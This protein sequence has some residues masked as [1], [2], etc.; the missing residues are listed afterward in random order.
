MAIAPL[1]VRITA[2][3]AAALA[4]TSAALRAA[5]AAAA[6]AARTAGTR[7]AP[8]FTRL[9]AALRAV[10][11]AAARAAAIIG[12]P[13]RRALRA[14]ADAA[15][16]L[17]RALL[18]WV[19][20]YGSIGALLIPLIVAVAKLGPL[21]MLLAPAALAAAGAFGAL[22]LGMSGVGDAIKA[23]LSG[24]TEEFAKALKKLTPAA[25]QFVKAVMAVRGG[26]RRMQQQVQEKLFVGLGDSLRNL[27]GK[28]LPH[29]AKWLGTIATLFNTFAREASAALVTPARLAQ[30]DF[31]FRNISRFISGMLGTVKAL[32]RALLDIAEA[33]AP[34]LGDLGESVKGIADRFADWIKQMKDNGT[35]AKWIEQAKGVFNQLMDI[36]KEIGRVFAA[37][38]QGTDSKGFLDSLRKSIQ[39]LADFLEGEDGQEMI[40]F[41]SDVAKAA[42]G[43]VKTLGDVVRWFQEGISILRQM[44][45]GE[46]DIIPLANNTAAAIAGVGNAFGWIGGVLGKLG[47]LVAGIRAAVASINAALASIRTSVVIDIITRNH[48]T[49]GYIRPIGGGGGGSAPSYQ[50]RAGGGPVRQGVPYIVGEKRA[51]VFM[52]GQSGRI[53][54]SVPGMGSAPIRIQIAPG[55]GGI[56]NP[57][58]ETVLQMF[59]GGQLKLT[60][61]RSNRVVPA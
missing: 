47:G 59:R 29:L 60:V 6:A 7:T 1:I 39:E 5:A 13:L 46:S 34:A 14:A 32:G 12:G 52:P 43:L 58:V 51:E 40:K 2:L 19:A 9:A 11:S 44:F 48:G 26:W 49:Q 16:N 25:Q 61:D 22:K 42:A 15:T 31:I 20:L 45:R 4:R 30:L 41:F 24:D 55:P 37:I 18:R 54:P 3:G 35:L 8:A 57:F 17:A 56:G 21:V 10:A 28:S 36:G 38:F 53:L 23:G 27:V 33:A 50:G